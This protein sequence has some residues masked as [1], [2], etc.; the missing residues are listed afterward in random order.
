MNRRASVLLA[1][2]PLLLGTSLA[3]SSELAAG[4]LLYTGE[5]M[6]RALSVI[7]SILLASLGVG[8]WSGI[9]DDGPVVSTLRRRWLFIFLAYILAAVYAAG[10]GFLVERTAR[11]LSQGLG[12]A[13]LG[14]L[15]M[16][17]GG[18]LLGVMSREARQRMTR[19][20][21]PFAL[22]AL[23]AGAGS[24]AVGIFAG[25]RIIPPSFLLLC[26]VLLSGASFIEALGLAEL[27]AGGA[28]EGG[29]S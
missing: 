28:E 25:S 2:P 8:I 29:V 16:Y 9:H 18:A 6:V 20:A 17:A 10:W 21:A 14:A 11:G 27:G 12:L 19:P 13:I 26:L 23:G 3:A 7:L 22:A 4:L 15:P 5:G 24:L 1:L